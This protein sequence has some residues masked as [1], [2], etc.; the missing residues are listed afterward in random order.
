MWAMV[1]FF[2]PGDAASPGTQSGG[3]L[4]ASQGLL[5]IAGWRLPLTR[6]ILSK[7]CDAAQQGALFSLMSLLESCTGVIAAP[8]MQQL[9]YA[10]TVVNGCAG[11]VYYAA[12]A[13]AVLSIAVVLCAAAPATLEGRLVTGAAGGGSDA[14]DS[15]TDAA[16]PQ[17]QKADD[18]DVGDDDTCPSPPQS[19]AALDRLLLHQMGPSPAARDEVRHTPSPP[20]AAAAVGGRAPRRRRAGDAGSAVHSVATQSTVHSIIVTRNVGAAWL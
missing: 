18:L 15:A 7:T 8:L 17:Q 19:R 20:V 1:A 14:D 6:A 9:V 5:V 16:D 10:N 2:G 13:L 3:G 4:W 11:C 12:S